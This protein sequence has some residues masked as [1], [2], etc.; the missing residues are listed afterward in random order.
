[1]VGSTSSGFSELGFPGKKIENMIK[2]G[3]IQNTASTFGVAK[4]PFVS[5]G[6][7]RE[8]EINATSII[9]TRTQA[10]HVPY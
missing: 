5:Y 6:K 7:K 8:G 3:K 2:M 1:M 10:Y 9:R 4:K